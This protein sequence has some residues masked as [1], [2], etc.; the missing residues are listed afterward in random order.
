MIFFVSFLGALFAILVALL[1]VYTYVKHR[2]IPRIKV[3]FRE[4]VAEIGPSAVFE[5][6]KLDP[7]EAM[8]QL[9]V[10]S[11]E[12][13]AAIAR[14][15]ASSSAAR[16]IYTCEDHGRCVGC[17][18]VLAQFEAIIRHQGEESFDEIEKSCYAQLREQ[19]AS[20]TL[21]D[22]EGE[23]ARQQR[24]AD[25]VV[26]TLVREGITPNMARSAVWSC[27]KSKRSTFDGWLSA[28][29]TGC[30]ESREEIVS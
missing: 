15:S 19:L 22:G 1:I 14:Q 10:P 24:I 4:F 13:A 9:G 23:T 30:V 28:A 3:G 17:P 18:K 11:A 7:I 26:E 12:A 6:A 29:R 8:R 2:L 25:R 20:D 5:N 27:G 21:L 16:V